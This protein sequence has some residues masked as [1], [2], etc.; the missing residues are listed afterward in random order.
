MQHMISL[1]E[2]R[3]LTTWHMMARLKFIGWWLETYHGFS[4]QEIPKYKRDMHKSIRNKKWKNHPLHN[5]YF[6]S[7]MFYF[8]HIL[9]NRKKDNSTPEAHRKRANSYVNFEG[10]PMQVSEVSSIG[11]F[12][13]KFVL[14]GR[15]H[16]GLGWSNHST[17]WPQ[18][19]EGW[20]GVNRTFWERKRS[21]TNM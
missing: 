7:I 5:A 4:E 1:N 21:K 12:S 14:N 9:Q 13:S 8:L 6:S 17:V 20:I 18:L 2:R 19:F 10:M 15:K 3:I 11:F 16:W